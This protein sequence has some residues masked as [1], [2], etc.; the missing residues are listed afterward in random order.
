MDPLRDATNPY[1]RNSVPRRLWS[2]STPLVLPSALAAG[3][4]GRDG[5]GEDPRGTPGTYDRS[6]RLS[7][8]HAGGFGDARARDVLNRSLPRSKRESRS[9]SG[10]DRA[11]QSSGYD[12]RRSTNGFERDP[13]RRSLPGAAQGADVRA[14]SAAELP[15]Q[16]QN[17]MPAIATAEPRFDER[18]RSM[19]AHLPARDEVRLRVGADTVN[20]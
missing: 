2:S 9:T 20:S 8:S 10:F 19:T 12:P 1:M 5:R 13:S 16:S 3:G 17:R 11:L 7:R 14:R 4:D 6:A 15:Q 18:S